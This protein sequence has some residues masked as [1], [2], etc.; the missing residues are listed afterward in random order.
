MQPAAFHLDEPPQGRMGR[1][2][3]RRLQHRQNTA[4]AKDHRDGEKKEHHL[5]YLVALRHGGPPGRVARGR[6]GQHLYR[7]RT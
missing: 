4:G 6:H 2:D 3:A 1:L 5:S 7:D